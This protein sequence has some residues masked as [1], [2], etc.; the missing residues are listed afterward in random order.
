[1][2]LKFLPIPVARSSF[3]PELMLNLDKRI[4]IHLL[5]GAAEMT[6]VDSTCSDPALGYQMPA[7]NLQRHPHTSH[8]HT[9]HMQRDIKALKTKPLKSIYFYDRMIFRLRLD[10]VSS[11]NWFL[12]RANLAYIGWISFVMN[13]SEWYLMCGGISFASLLLRE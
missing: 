1:M 10:S 13:Y 9:W 11:I 5:E 3:S 8:T 2:R 12:S 6:L 4:S 7:Y